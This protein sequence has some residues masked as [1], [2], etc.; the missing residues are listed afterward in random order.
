MQVAYFSRFLCRCETGY[1][2]LG[3]EHG[4]RFLRWMFG[5]SREKQ[6]AGENCIIRT[7]MVCTFRQLSLG[8]RMKVDEWAFVAHIGEEKCIQNFG[9][10]RKE[11]GCLEDLGL[12]DGIILK[13]I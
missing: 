13:C 5:H 9:G 6:E 10:E 8:D 2:S 1:L 7:F 12:E 3:E 4:L 11:R